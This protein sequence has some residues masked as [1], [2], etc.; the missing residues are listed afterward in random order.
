MEGYLMSMEL[1][2]D[3][4]TDAQAPHETSDFDQTNNT[5]D[6]IWTLRKLTKELIPVEQQQERSRCL[7]EQSSSKSLEVLVIRSI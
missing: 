2:R 7:D 4:G 6:E 3:V 1:Y 5:R